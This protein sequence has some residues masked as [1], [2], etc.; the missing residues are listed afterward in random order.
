MSQ[1]G[2]S[3]HLLSVIVVIVIF[4]TPFPNCSTDHLH[5]LCVR[6]LDGHLHSLIII[7]WVIPLFFMEFWTISLKTFLKQFARNIV[8]I[9]KV[10]VDDHLVVRLVF[11]KSASEL[12]D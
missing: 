3:D 9:L 12:I 5:I 6:S 8:L 10:S 7:I 4:S 11:G 1:G 2:F